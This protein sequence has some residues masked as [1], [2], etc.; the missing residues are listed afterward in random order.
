MNAL[1]E[2]RDFLKSLTLETGKIIVEYFAQDLK[3]EIKSDHSPVTIVDKKVEELL[4]DRISREFPEHGIIGE[5]FGSKDQD[6]EYVWVI[7]PIDGTKSFISRVPLF[8]TL[9]ALTHNR[10]PI[11][12]VFHQP[13]LNLFLIGDNRD[14]F[15]NDRKIVTREI[16]SISQARLFTSDIMDIQ[17]YQDLNK[18]LRLAEK[19]SLVRTWGDCF[20]YYLL[21]CGMGDIMLDPIV[22]D[23]DAMAVIP[24]A[25]GAGAKVTDFKGGDLKNPRSL[26]A[27]I[28]EIHKRVIEILH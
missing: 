13:L 23:W 2:C 26:V 9:I 8:G 20:G 1:K 22:N 16:R 25:R 12:G 10:E 5:E 7:D 4:R 19:V 27:A 17:K 11:L 6:S 15:L 21:S 18:F 3:I 28:P 14:S 24:I